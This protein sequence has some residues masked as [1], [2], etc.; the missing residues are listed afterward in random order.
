VWL[1]PYYN[2][3]ILAKSNI[4]LYIQ[5]RNERYISSTLIILGLALIII[6]NWIYEINDIKNELSCWQM[7]MRAFA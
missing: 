1:A 2:L 5:I 4:I 3:G 6:I 7:L